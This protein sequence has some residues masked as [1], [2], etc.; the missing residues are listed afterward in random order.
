MYF[1]AERLNGSSEFSFISEATHDVTAIVLFLQ[2]LLSLKWTPE[3]SFFVYKA[4]T[5]L[6]VDT[7]IQD[8][9]KIPEATFTLPDI[10]VKRYFDGESV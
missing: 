6:V 2:G 5:H 9:T 7:P 4:P 3:R 10:F 8:R 1:I